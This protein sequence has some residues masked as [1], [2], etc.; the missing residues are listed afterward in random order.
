DEKYS[1]RQIPVGWVY[2]NPFNGYVH[3]Q[4]LKIFETKIANNLV[5]EDSIFF[6]AK[7]LSANVA[8]LKLASKTI[9]ITKLTLNQPEGFIIQN[10]NNLNFNDL[11]QKFT[12]DK[13]EIILDTFH[14]NILKMKIKNG[15]FHYR[16]K[17]IPIN[18]FIKNVNIESSGIYWNVDTLAA[19]FSFCSGIGTGN[20]AGDITINLKNMDYNLAIIVQQF[21]LNIIQQYLKDLASYGTFNAYLNADIQSKGNFKSVEKVTNKGVVVIQD[22]HFGKN[23]NEDYAAFDK[24][25]VGI[26][27]ISPDKP[28]YW[29]DSI[30]LI[31]PYFKYERYDDLDNLQT[32]FGENGSNISAVTDDSTSFNLVLEVANYVKKLG[33][34]FYKS[35]FKIDKLKIEQGAFC[36]NDYSLSEKF[37]I[38]TNQLAIIAD[39]INKMNDRLK[40][41][42]KSDIEPYGD[43]YV[44]LSLNPNDSRDFDMQYQLQGMPVTLFNPYLINYTSYPFDRG[45][46]ELNGKWN[47][48][49]GKINSENHI[50][51]IDPRI[52]AKL[53]NNDSKYIPLPLIMYII[54]ERG[55]VIDYSIP[56][57]GNLKDPTFHLSDVV[58]DMLANVI[59]KPPSI[60]YRTEIRNIENEIEKSL[61]LTWNPVQN[62]LLSKQKEFTNKMVD[63][64]ANHPDETIDIYPINYSRKEKEHILFFEAKKKYYLSTRKDKNNLNL[65]KTDS[66]EV[67]NMSAKDDKFVLYLKDNVNDTL[68]FTV[69]D[70]CIKFLG[71]DTINAKFEQLSNERQAAFMSPFNFKGLSNRVTMNMGV[72]KIPYNGFSFYKIV[73][74]G[75]LPPYLIKAYQQLNEYNDEA[76]RKQFEVK[77]EKNKSEVSLLN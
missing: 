8:L 54:K 7:G 34:N 63:F 59:L 50:L 15:V 4:N 51:V 18:Y 55:N 6:S 16:E 64:L 32:I 66:I 19:K 36:F 40:F 42:F 60:S 22:F 58:F 47:V 57:S 21:N 49:N 67:E 11:I 38:E 24:L 53:E 2:F 73:Y 12:P 14:F 26:H 48:R 56:I 9:E 72:N 65:S 45:T 27:E 23:P 74:R 28:V 62:V 68:V 35:N 77:R 76:P 1:G 52:Q 25:V 31:H 46:L 41:S 3:I 69:Q 29:Y 13:S 44:N 17:L 39:S 30:L 10:K 75:E 20:A 5:P 43:M 61:S 37:S 70:L 71:S 33:T